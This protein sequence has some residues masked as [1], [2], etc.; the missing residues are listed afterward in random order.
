MPFLTS[1]ESRGAGVDEEDE[2]VVLVEPETVVTVVVV[3]EAAAAAIPSTFS[4]DGARLLPSEVKL[5]P[6]DF[7]A[8]SSV[9]RVGPL[10]ISIRDSE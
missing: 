5:L 8:A 6:T 3:V 7:E 4:I 9:R 1:G 10:V 2:V